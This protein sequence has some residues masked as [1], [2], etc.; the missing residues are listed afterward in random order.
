MLFLQ[1]GTTKM[2]K[3]Y[4]FRKEHQ[5]VKVLFLQK[6]IEKRWKCCSFGKEQ[7]NAKV[8][9]LRKGIA[10]GKNVVPS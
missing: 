3:C 7:Q 4:S 6:G 8:F 1:K 2:Q 10:N 9:F 5:N